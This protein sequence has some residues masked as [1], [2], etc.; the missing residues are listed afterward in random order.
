MNPEQEEGEKMAADAEVS[1]GSELPEP[2]IDPPEPPRPDELH[3]W[4]PG[5]TDESGDLPVSDDEVKDEPAE[6]ATTEPT[7]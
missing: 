6:V 1:L 2:S 5:L 3:T 7:G 4:S